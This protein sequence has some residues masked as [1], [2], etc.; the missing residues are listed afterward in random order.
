MAEGM[1]PEFVASATEKM[2][3]INAAYDTVCKMRGF[4]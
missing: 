1:P 4:K 3:R 2:K